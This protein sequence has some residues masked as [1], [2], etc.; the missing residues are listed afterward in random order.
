VADAIYGHG[1][2]ECLLALLHIIRASQ[3]PK[4]GME[5]QLEEL[6]NCTEEQT[7]DTKFGNSLHGFLQVA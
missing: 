5:A 1:L 2:N 4:L 7:I 3:R 6:A